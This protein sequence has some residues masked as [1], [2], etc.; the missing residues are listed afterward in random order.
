MIE[1]AK[2]ILEKFDIFI[3]RKFRYITKNPAWLRLDQDQRW[4]E[5]AFLTTN[6]FVSY[7]NKLRNCY[8]EDNLKRWFPTYLILHIGDLPRRFEY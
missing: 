3:E 5:L 2:T 4:Y 6:L 1:I 8:L 7:L